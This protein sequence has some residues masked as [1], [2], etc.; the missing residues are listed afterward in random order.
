MN[1]QYYNLHQRQL[2]GHR[3]I[4][5][6]SKYYHCNDKKSTVPWLRVIAAIIESDEALN[7]KRCFEISI[8]SLVQRAEKLGKSF[9]LLSLRGLI[10]M[11]SN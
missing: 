5:N 9:T 7:L 11:L 2:L 10:L 4:E 8:P 6:D 3:C 1:N